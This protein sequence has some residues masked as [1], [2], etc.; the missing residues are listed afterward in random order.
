MLAFLVMHI[1]NYGMRKRFRI[2]RLGKFG[3]LP[4][5]LAI[6]TPIVV[7]S[8][9]FTIRLSTPQA[10]HANTE[11]CGNLSAG[12]FICLMHNGMALD[13]N[14][15][16]PF[17][18]VGGFMAGDGGT[19][20]FPIGINP[21]VRAAFSGLSDEEILGFLWGGELA[22]A[23]RH[24]GG[25]PED[26][27]CAAAGWSASLSGLTVT[28]TAGVNQEPFPI[29]CTII[30]GHALNVQHGQGDAATVAIRQ[31]V[32]GEEADGG[33]NLPP[34]TITPP[35]GG[36]EAPPREVSC[37]LEQLGWML[38]P[39]ISGVDRML[40]GLYG[41]IESYFLQ[42]DIQ[43]YNTSSGTYE[44]WGTFRNIANI[45]FV[46][47]F[48]VVIFSQVTSI[49]ISNY[50][51]KKMLPEIIMA[52]VLI[53]LSFFI[54]QAM[55]D[56]SNIVGYQVNSLL[57]NLISAPG[58]AIEVEGTNPGFI[59]RAFAVIGI[60]GGGILLGLVLTGG[61]GP[62]LAA[63]MLLLISAFVAVLVLFILL[64]LRQVGIIVL[65]VIAPLAF[66]AR[67]LPGT[68]GLFSS[69]WKMFK[70][71]LVVYPACGLVI[72]G[73]VL[74][75]RIIAHAGGAGEVLPPDSLPP[76]SLPPIINPD[77]PI[78]DF[79]F[80]APSLIVFGSIA[81]T[82]CWWATIIHGNSSERKHAVHRSCNSP[83][84]PILCC[85]LYHK[86]IA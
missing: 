79:N 52:A 83:N 65:I 59:A 9:L 38:C 35:S 22:V 78:P 4:I 20:E 84:C 76:D 42:I 41:M 45:L 43:F 53:N 63:V 62:L 51:I 11:N 25:D 46:I 55:V 64:V 24:I 27:R 49:G 58:G 71:L 16:R 67:I 32:E 5:V 1:Y 57:S 47:F 44:A 31:N 36:G 69:W 17:Q 48:L 75:A 34:G 37:D 18:F 8:A 61:I 13:A 66:A 77:G 33:T 21:D 2:Q 56:L 40:G 80:N 86:R 74:V 39:I 60:V 72:G 6:V 82:R 70:S 73:G 15:G 68:V 85:Y 30:L 10:T 3:R 19:L 23:V 26:A 12:R 28:V 50:G 81:G 7:L 54:A 29:L 14:D